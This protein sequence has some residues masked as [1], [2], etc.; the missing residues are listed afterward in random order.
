[1]LRPSDVITTAESSIPHRTSSLCTVQPLPEGHDGAQGAFRTQK[2]ARLGESQKVNLAAQYHDYEN[3]YLGAGDFLFM[4]YLSLQFWSTFNTWNFRYWVMFLFL[5]F[6]AHL[7]QHL[8]VH[9]LLKNLFDQEEFSVDSPFESWSGTFFFIISPGI[10]LLGG[11]V[12]VIWR[13]AKHSHTVV[14][15]TT[16]LV[17]ISE[18]V[19]LVGEGYDK[20]T[21]YALP[22]PLM[23]VAV[24]LTARL[25]PSVATLTTFVFGLCLVGGT[26]ILRAQSD[27]FSALNDRLV[28][29]KKTDGSYELALHGVSHGMVDYFKKCYNSFFFKRFDRTV[30]EQTY[31]LWYSSRHTYW[32]T[33]HSRWAVI[34]FIL[35]VVAMVFAA[36]EP[37]RGPEGEPD[38]SSYAGITVQVLAAVMLLV[39]GFIA[40]F[41][42]GRKRRLMLSA[43][44]FLLACCLFSC[45]YVYNFDRSAR[46]SLETEGSTVFYHTVWDTDPGLFTIIATHITMSHMGYLFLLFL[47]CVVTLAVTFSALLWLDTS[48]AQLVV[49]GLVNFLLMMLMGF[50][51][52][53]A[54]DSHWRLLFALTRDPVPTD[55]KEK[56][57]IEGWSTEYSERTMY[58]I[59]VKAGHESSYK[60]LV[61][62]AELRSRLVG[63]QDRLCAYDAGEDGWTQYIDT[64]LDCLDDLSDGVG[65]TRARRLETLLNGV[66]ARYPE[67]IPV[68]FPRAEGD[69]VPRMNITLITVGSRGDVQPFMAL[70]R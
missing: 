56:I 41:A 60:I 29:R 10:W 63:I 55:P 27:L 14:A 22:V 48:S 47:D 2:T 66:A 20:T 32:I 19:I 46:K 38:F 7:S 42:Y 53:L 21:V 45:V 25:I 59:T 12:L 49:A 11:L 31:R 34:G 61:S 65:H 5:C 6:L 51:Y 37:F 43:M 52:T 50:L 1:M 39:A 36:V 54:I 30:D 62:A 26:N 16:I 24:G 58:Y 17:V 70:A 18:F 67:M 64:S 3:R 57:V 44:M 4:R 35:L 15:V 68:L 33:H 23:L 28:F 40:M 8:I 69:N 9:F 13:P